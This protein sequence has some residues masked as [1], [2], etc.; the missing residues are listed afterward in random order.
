MQVQAYAARARALWGEIDGFVN[1]AGIK[2]AVRPII[3]FPE[4]DFDRLMAINVRG[5]FLGMKYASNHPEPR[6]GRKY[7]QFT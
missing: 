6:F 4:E 2:T 1:N 7:V 5:V 3:E